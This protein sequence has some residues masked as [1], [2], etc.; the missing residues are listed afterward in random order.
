MRVLDV[1][2]MFGS[3]AV[4]A[5]VVSDHSVCGKLFIKYQLSRILGSEIKASLSSGF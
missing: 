5:V 4:M 2:E 1:V 3:D